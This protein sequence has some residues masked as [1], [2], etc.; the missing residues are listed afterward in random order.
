MKTRRSFCKKLVT[1]AVAL[2]VAPALLA[3][4][5]ATT[6]FTEGPI[7]YPITWKGKTIYFHVEQEDFCRETGYLTIGGCDEQAT[8]NNFRDRL[9]FKP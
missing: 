5:E 3:G 1:S 6:I 4:S 2:T 9:G 7:V 8:I